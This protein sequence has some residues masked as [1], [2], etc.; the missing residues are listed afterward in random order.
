[1]EEPSVL[2]YMYN[3]KTYW[4]IYVALGKVT[5]LIKGKFLWCFSTHEKGRKTNEKV[6]L[7][8]NSDVARKSGSQI[9]NMTNFPEIVLKSVLNI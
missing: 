1:M 9:I 4:V 5:K 2:W 7:S 3:L 6:W 8:E